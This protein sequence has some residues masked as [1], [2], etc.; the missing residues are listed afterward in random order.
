MDRNMEILEKLKNLDDDGLRAII[1]E[2]AG[3]MGMNEGMRRA[4]LSHTGMIR[5][6]LNK[7][8]REDLE[9]AIGMV[10]KEKAE[11]IIG[12]LKR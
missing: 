3:A 8:S 12:K 11:E 6:R 10:G 7:A 9:K 2:V 1:N 5:R 4:A